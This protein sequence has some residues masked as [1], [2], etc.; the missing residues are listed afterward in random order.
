MKKTKTLQ[1][2]LTEDLKNEIVSEAS[3][4]NTSISA[5]AI[6]AIIEKLNRTQKERG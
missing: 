5:Y 4:L 2:R 6:A 1:I 3:R